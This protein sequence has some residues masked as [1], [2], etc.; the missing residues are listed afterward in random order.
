MPQA[1]CALFTIWRVQRNDNSGT[2]DSCYGLNGFAQHRDH[3]DR[4]QV[5]LFQRQ[6]QFLI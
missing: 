6:S 3:G 1:L 4:V 5:V 2:V